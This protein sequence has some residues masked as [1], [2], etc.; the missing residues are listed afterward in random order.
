[1]KKIDRTGET[2]TNKYGSEMTIIK[3]HNANDMVV[4]F[5]NDYK[6]KPQ[7]KDFKKGNVK[8][9]YDKT[10]FNIGYLGEGIYTS[11]TNNIKNI[12][13]IYWISLF[14]RCYGESELLKRPRYKDCTI[15]EEWHNFQNFAEWFD[16]NYYEIDNE[17][18][19][20]DK[21][22]LVKGNKV[23][24]PDTCI[25]VPDRI[26]CL[27][28]KSNNVRGDYPIGVSK[29]RNTTNK[30]FLCRCNTLDKSVY[31]GHYQTPEEAFYKGYKPF[32]EQY[33]KQVANEYKDKI[34]KVLYDALYRYEVEITD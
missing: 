11:R 33:I 18:M 16:N 15:C 17:K 3:Y 31:L 28:V 5:K 6:T 26:N 27:F 9:P 13:Y 32:K 34:P 20:L 24:S 19:C 8:N 30:H 10:V 7:Y 12:Q 14:S 4:E 25:F 21:D 29:S 23:Y 1:M 22:I 2:N